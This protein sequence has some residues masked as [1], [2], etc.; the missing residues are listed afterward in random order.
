MENH[1]AAEI[2]EMTARFVVHG[3]EKSAIGGD[4]DSRDVGRALAW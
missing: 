4:G 2:D 3:N 1:P